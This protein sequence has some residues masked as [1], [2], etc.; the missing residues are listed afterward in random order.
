M[1]MNM[2]R[3]S[4]TPH[5]V[6]SIMMADYTAGRRKQIMSPTTANLPLI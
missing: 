5:R 4:K 1:G 3:K 2:T 6:G